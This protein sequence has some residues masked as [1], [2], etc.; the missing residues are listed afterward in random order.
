MIK[1]ITYIFFCCFLITVKMNAQ[2]EPMY[3][4]YMY[5]QLVINPAYA[6][7]REVLT[8]NSY[9]RKQWMGIDGAP[10]TTSV[11]LDGRAIG[12]R[13][14]FGV[15]LF[16]DHLGVEKATGVNT[17]LSTSVNLTEGGVLSGGLM[18]GMMNYRSDMTQVTNRFSASDPVFS[19]NFSKWIPVLGMGL[20][21]NTNKFYTGISIP[22]L[23]H[24]RATSLEVIKSGFQKINDIHVFATAGYVLDLNEDVKLKPSMMMKFVSGAPMA[25]DLNTNILLKEYLGVGVSYRI[26]DAVVGMLECQLT[27][28]IKLGYAYDQTISSVS[29]FKPKSHEIMLRFDFGNGGDGFKL[30]R[31]F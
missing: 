8:L 27:P 25:L 21:Y 2:T 18:V 15:Q 1:K 24:S 23:L 20:F 17:M 6:G 29:A 7:N 19:N 16:D 22:N 12:N 3:S 26:G 5:N 13:F 31:F 9:Y 30:N 4:Q 14:G 10:Q 11:S 28:S